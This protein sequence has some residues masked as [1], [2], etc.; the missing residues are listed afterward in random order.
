MKPIN[1][2]NDFSK[3]M[4]KLRSTKNKKKLALKI[5]KYLSESIKKHYF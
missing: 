1:N 5:S 4:K 3:A 2:E